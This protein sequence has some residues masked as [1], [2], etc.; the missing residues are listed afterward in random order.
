MWNRFSKKMGLSY[1]V[2]G[3]KTSSDNS[4]VNKNNEINKIK[5]KSV[6]KLQRWF[7]GILF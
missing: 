5:N 2:P 1:F 7:V 3:C 4:S 6:F